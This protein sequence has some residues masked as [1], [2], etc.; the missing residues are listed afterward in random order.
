MTN[1]PPVKTEDDQ[2]P[3][4][5][6]TDED[7]TKAEPHQWGALQYGLMAAAGGV[8]AAVGTSV[9]FEHEQGPGLFRQFKGARAGE[10]P[11]I[12]V[13]GDGNC[14]YRTIAVLEYGSQDRWKQVKQEILR[15]YESG[16]SDTAGLIKDA[17]QHQH[18]RKLLKTANA[19]AEG[20]MVRLA[21]E[22]YGHPIHVINRMGKQMGEHL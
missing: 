13:A 11:T 21:E 5:E 20:P 16:N 15:F 4:N 3:V 18:V 9:A 6:T 10:V 14:F 22:L 17:G 1:L 19:W 2:K 8:A 12:P 7:Q